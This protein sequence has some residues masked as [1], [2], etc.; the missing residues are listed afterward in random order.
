M[1][2]VD[3][4]SDLG[5]AFGE[6]KMGLDHEILPH[7]STANIACGFHAGDP[8]TMNKTVELAVKEN[9]SF[10]AHPGFP[11]LLG[12]GRRNL[13]C[14]A[15]E[16]TAYVQYQIGALQAF[17]HSHG[18][19]LQHVKPHGALYNM[20][21][22]DLVVANAIIKAICNVDKSLILL[23]LSGSLMV[24]LGAEADL[25][26]ASEVFADRGY[27]PNGSLASRNE[28]GGIITD[29]KLAIERTIEMVTKGTVTAITGEKISI[30][31]DSICVHGDNP[32]AVAFVKEI[33]KELEKCGCTIAPLSQ[34]VKSC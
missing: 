31:A 8:I 13:S 1:K 9:V 30:K 12:F 29:E 4:N 3:I 18:K 33:R 32:S 10:G 16:I 23:A 24:K 2:Y 20:A 14:S 11:D 34:V 27:M 15:D 7:I 26:V 5:E 28:K 25:T 6:Y 22:N 19:K 17:A 21:V